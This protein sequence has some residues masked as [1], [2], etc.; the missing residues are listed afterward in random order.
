MAPAPVGNECLKKWVRF[1]RL[2]RLGAE[3]RFLNCPRTQLVTFSEVSDTVLKFYFHHLKRFFD[4]IFSSK[5]RHF[6][7]LKT[8]K[9]LG[10]GNLAASLRPGSV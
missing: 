7:V 10:P 8:L 9:G 4:V 6:Q 1:A 5:N 3:I 2:L